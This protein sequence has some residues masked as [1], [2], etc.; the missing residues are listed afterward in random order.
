VWDHLR[1]QLDPVDA[2]RAEAR[3]AWCRGVGA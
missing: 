1:Y 3:L 2:A